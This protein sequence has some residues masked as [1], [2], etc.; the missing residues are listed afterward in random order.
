MKI[1]KFNV[2]ISTILCIILTIV[3][4]YLYLT[5][6][7]ENRKNQKLLIDAYNKQLKTYKHQI[8]SL[9]SYYKIVDNKI[10]KIQQ[11]K[12]SAILAGNKLQIKIVTIQKQT[13]EDIQ[14]VRSLTNSDTYRMFAEYLS[15][16]PN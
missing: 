11:Q 8:D 12:D 10:T 13:N 15:K 14:N 9:H 4:A 7:N 1:G 2:S 16:Q 6:A 5:S 3:F